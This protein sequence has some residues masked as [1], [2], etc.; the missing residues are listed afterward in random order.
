LKFIGSTLEV[1]WEVFSTGQ[2][3][4]VFGVKGLLMNSPPACFDR[5]INCE[6]AN[7]IVLIMQAF[8]DNSLI[9]RR[10]S[11]ILNAASKRNDLHKKLLDAGSVRALNDAVTNHGGMILFGKLPLRQ[12]INY[13]YHFN[14]RLAVSSK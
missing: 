11:W 1:P 7:L 10:A 4:F 14:N 6:G 2:V 13:A 12:W 3:F 5:F 8:P 9:Q